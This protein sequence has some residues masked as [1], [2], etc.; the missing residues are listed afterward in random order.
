[1]TDRNQSDN[2]RFFQ[3]IMARLMNSSIGRAAI[4]Y[5]S[6]ITD[7]FC[8]TYA[9]S[10]GRSQFDWSVILQKYLILL[11]SSYI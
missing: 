8:W 10:M 2:S 7:K 9:F 3:T 6:I 11:K 5:Q 1:M 4:E